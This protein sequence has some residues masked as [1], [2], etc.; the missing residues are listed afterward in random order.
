MAYMKPR[1]LDANGFFCFSGRYEEAIEYYTKAKET[2]TTP[3]NHAI[4]AHNIA[5]C[6]YKMRQYE[7]ARD[8]AEKALHIFKDIPQ[9]HERVVDVR[10]LLAKIKAQQGGEAR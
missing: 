8:Y 7:Q 2:N 1:N 10:D 6:Y 4:L 5:E 3:F 9:A